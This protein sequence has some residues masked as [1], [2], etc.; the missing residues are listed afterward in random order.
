MA[1]QQATG[2]EVAAFGRAVDFKR[3]EGVVRACGNESAGRTQPW[4]EQESVGF[5]EANQ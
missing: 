5:D 4:A 1:A 3:F 2:H